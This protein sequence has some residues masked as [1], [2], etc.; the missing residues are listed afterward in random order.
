MS[1][2]SEVSS[3]SPN[4]VLIGG[5]IG[6]I[7]GVLMIGTGVFLVIFLLFKRIKHKHTQLA[8]LNTTI[9]RSEITTKHSSQSGATNQTQLLET[10]R[11]FAKYSQISLSEITIEKELGEGSHGRVYLGKWHAGRVALK[12]CKN[13]AKLEKFM[14]EI[15]LMVE[16]PPHPNVVQVFG[17]SLDGPQPVI[18]M[19]YCAGGSLDTLLFG[20]NV[21]L[22]D[23]QKIRFVRG[24]ALGMKHLHEHN[25]VHRDLA[26]RNIL[27]TG[28]GDSKISRIRIMFCRILECREL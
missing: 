15:K 28:S 18:V 24:I 14:N 19:E 8:N 16:L 11:K 25:I 17:V 21:K 6:A 10:S 27:L 4:N 3:T 9:S 23:E 13:N 2:T 7:G 20:D 5:L 22:S 1:S 26:A 12:F